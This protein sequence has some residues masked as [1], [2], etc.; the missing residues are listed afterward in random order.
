MA[1]DV[2]HPALHGLQRTRQV[3]VSA[4]PVMLAFLAGQHHT[5]HMLLLSFGLG[6]AGVSFLTMYPSIRRGM[7]A[8][9]L[10]VAAVLVYQATRPGRSRAMR[11]TQGLS[12]LT[13]VVL[14]GWSVGEFGL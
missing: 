8:V 2:A 14:I 3:L 4:G 12:V 1:T 5:V 9:S 13:T 11:V 6:T 10:A 7:L